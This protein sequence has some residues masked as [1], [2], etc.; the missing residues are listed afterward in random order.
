MPVG[1]HARSQQVSNARY[2]ILTGM[3]KRLQVVMDDAEYAD[4]EQAAQREGET[5]S[6]WVRQALRNARQEQP[7]VEIARKLALLRTTHAM[8]GPTGDIEILLE[9]TARG[10]LHEL[11]E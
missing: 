5:V 3:S 11:P 1:G 8:S 7:E 2:G 6:Q 9:E 10:Y 4:I